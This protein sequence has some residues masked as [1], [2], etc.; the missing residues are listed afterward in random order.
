MST[1]IS[2]ATNIS[3]TDAGTTKFTASEVLVI[4]AASAGYALHCRLV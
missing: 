3:A 4:P 1:I 2:I